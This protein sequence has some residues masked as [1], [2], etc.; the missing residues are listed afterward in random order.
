MSV[1]EE[2]KILLSPSMMKEIH[3]RKFFLAVS[4]E[5]IQYDTVSCTEGGEDTRPKTMLLLH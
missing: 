3:Q 1:F 2:Q 4:K 5:E